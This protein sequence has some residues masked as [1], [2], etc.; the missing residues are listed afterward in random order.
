MISLS[1]APRNEIPKARQLPMNDYNNLSRQTL[2]E[3][4]E[5]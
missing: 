3:G 1:Q 4:G 2:E 5:A